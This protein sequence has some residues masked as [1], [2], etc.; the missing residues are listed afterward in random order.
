[1]GVWRTVE[2]ALD[3]N[4]E[5]SGRRARESNV[6]HGQMDVSASPRTS[7]RRPRAKI[8]QRRQTCRE[9]THLDYRACMWLA[10]AYKNFQD[11][12]S[13]R[14]K[15]VQIVLLRDRRR[16]RTQ[17]GKQKNK[18]RSRDTKRETKLCKLVVFFRRSLTWAALYPDQLQRFQRKPTCHDAPFDCFVSLKFRSDPCCVAHQVV[19]ANSRP[20]LSPRTRREVWTQRQS[21]S[22]LCAVI[23]HLYAHLHSAHI[24]IRSH[25]AKQADMT[26]LA[27]LGFAYC[28]CVRVRVHKGMGAGGAFKWSKQEVRWQG[29]STAS[30]HSPIYINPS[31]TEFWGGKKQTAQGP[32]SNLD[33]H[34]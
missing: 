7:W 33:E 13:R 30:D 8:V 17:Q 18:S 12:V 28:V 27:V 19:P 25:Y 10:Q 21:K 4:Q 31:V 2:A 24:V 1:M 3:E 9:P 26:A 34:I 16:R 22:H 11:D 23:C 32:S 15:A 14:L 5:A 29:P 20:I 6:H